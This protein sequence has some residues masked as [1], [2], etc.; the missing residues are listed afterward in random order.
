MSFGGRKS[1]EW[2]A[3]TP[4]G[5]GPPRPGKCVLFHPDKHRQ[6]SNP[7]RGC[8]I[9]SPRRPTY[10]PA[11]PSSDKFIYIYCIRIHFILRG[12]NRTV[13]SEEKYLFTAAVAATIQSDRNASLFASVRCFT[14]FYVCFRFGVACSKITTTTNRSVFKFIS[15]KTDNVSSYWDF[16][17]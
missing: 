15:H 17:I 4:V 7:Y 13:A 11:K 16:Q 9:F 2:K 6:M 8:H 5:D 1:S 10:T 3:A 14:L 12:R